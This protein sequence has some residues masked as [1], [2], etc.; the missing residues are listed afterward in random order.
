MLPAS[1]SVVSISRDFPYYRLVFDNKQNLLVTI[2]VIYNFYTN[3]VQV[4]SVTSTST[5]TATQNN[6]N[7]GSN[8]VS[9]SSGTGSQSQA[10]MQSQSSSASSQQTS[11]QSNLQ[12]QTSSSSSSSSSTSSKQIVCI[13]GFTRYDGSNPAMTT[14]L[15][16]GMQQVSNNIARMGLRVSDILYQDILYKM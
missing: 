15:L 2:N 1:S 5:N 4:M 7:A 14:F 8:T 6:S 10:Q 11:T 3:T 12:T 13:D 9:T 16:Q